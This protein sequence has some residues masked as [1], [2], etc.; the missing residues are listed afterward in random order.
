MEKNVIDYHQIT[1]LLVL[2]VFRCRKTVHEVHD[3]FLEETLNHIF[4]LT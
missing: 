1:T 4:V 2:S 3:V